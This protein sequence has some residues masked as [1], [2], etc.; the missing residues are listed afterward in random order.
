M[1]RNDIHTPFP[2]LCMQKVF[3]PHKG[4]ITSLEFNSSGNFILSS[5]TDS[6]IYLHSTSSYGQTHSYSGAHI[7]SVNSLSLSH[8]NEQF[9][10][11]SNE[12]VLWDLSVGSILRKFQD[13]SNSRRLQKICQAKF[14]NEEASL[15]ASCGVDCAVKIFDM[16]SSSSKPVNSYTDAKDCVNCFD[17][18]DNHTIVA[19]SNDGSLYG[20]DL[21]MGQLRVDHMGSAITHV[22]LSVNCKTDDLCWLNFLDTHPCKYDF[23]TGSKLSQYR[24]P[25]K[26]IGNFKLGSV[27]AGNFFITGSELG[28]IYAFDSELPGICDADVIPILEE[29][30]QSG[31]IACSVDYD[32]K[33]QTLAVGC[34]DGR[35]VLIDL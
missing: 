3:H 31:M 17:F 19:G 15:V 11:C 23:V 34:D 6:R 29:K 16:R 7:D 10:S 24:T 9:I 22:C 21:R 1:S 27:L 18:N 32:E 30:K 13:F 8:T 20:Y 5:C 4:S 26:A 35:C 14:L 28:E 12:I 25:E 2:A 33:S